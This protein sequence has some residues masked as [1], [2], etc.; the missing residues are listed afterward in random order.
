MAIVD[1][2]NL[3]KTGKRRMGR[4]WKITMPMLAALL[5]AGGVLAVQPARRGCARRRGICV[6]Q[7]A[8]TPSGRA[9]MSCWWNP[10]VS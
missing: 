3:K 2:S 4:G 6:M 5:T 8:R 9:C 10:T 7:A 1:L